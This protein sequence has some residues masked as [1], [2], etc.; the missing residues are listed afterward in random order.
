LNSDQKDDALRRVARAQASLRVLKK[1]L[2]ETFDKMK[3]EA[4][5]E[6]EPA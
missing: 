2:D 6:R 4:D 1:G 5:A 3:E